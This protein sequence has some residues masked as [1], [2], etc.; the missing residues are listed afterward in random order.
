MIER[1]VHQTRMVASS[2]VVAWIVGV[3]RLHER[4]AVEVV[5]VR[6]ALVGLVHELRELVAVGVGCDAPWA[7]MRPRPP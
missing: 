1:L 5:P 2:Q 3:S 6:Q 7:R 4:K